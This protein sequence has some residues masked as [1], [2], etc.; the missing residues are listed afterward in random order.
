M[1]LLV[2]VLAAGGTALWNTFGYSRSQSSAAGT[3]GSGAANEPVNLADAHDVAPVT[4]KRE[5]AADKAADTHANLAAWTEMT[6]VSGSG[7]S[8][9]GSAAGGD[10]GAEEGQ[11]AEEGQGAEGGGALE[12]D[13]KG[14]VTVQLRVPKVPPSYNRWVLVEDMLLFHL[15]ALQQQLEQVY[16][17]MGLAAATGRGFILPEFQCFCQNSEAP[18]PRCRQPHSG[19]LDFPAA[20]SQEDVLV[21]LEDFQS[22]PARSGTPL[23][24]RPASTAKA[25]A[26]SKDDLLILRPSATILFPTCLGT[27][28]PAGPGGSEACT[29]KSSREG[30]EGAHVLLVPPSLNDTDLLPLLEAA[31]KYPVWELDFSDIGSHWHAFRGWDCQAPTHQFDLRMSKVVKPWPSPEAAAKAAG[32]GSAA[33]FSPTYALNMTAGRRFSDEPDMK[34]C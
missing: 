5:E 20:C 9:D 17:G 18:L 1:L 23:D 31:K 8:G 19:G 11:Q 21:A 32:S 29:A 30:E 34:D 14:F 28:P 4:Q 25:L 22:D 26:G 27:P 10:G 7:S 2:V 13:A 33:A 15:R 12:G 16:V 24:V 3:V 6:T